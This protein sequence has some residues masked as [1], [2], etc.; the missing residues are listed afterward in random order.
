MG[1]VWRSGLGGVAALAA[2]AGLAFLGHRLFKSQAPKVQK[3]GA[4]AQQQSGGGGCR[5]SAAA[6]QQS[7]DGGCR[8][9]VT[10]QQRSAEGGCRGSVTAQQQSGG[11]RIEHTHGLVTAGVPSGVQQCFK[12]LVVPRC[13]RPPRLRCCCCCHF[14]QGGSRHSAVATATLH[15]CPVLATAAATLHLWRL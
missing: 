9:S 2:F 8:G 13:H 12:A 11:M 14:P 4:A 1:V 3:V 5:G 6:Q 7:G 10:A 15:L